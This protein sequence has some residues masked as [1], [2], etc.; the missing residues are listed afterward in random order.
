MKIELISLAALACS[1]NAS[2]A[3]LDKRN[4]AITADAVAFTGNTVD[5]T[6]SLDYTDLGKRATLRGDCSPGQK[7]TIRTAL[8]N[9]YRVAGRAAAVA[10][11]NHAKLK[12]FFK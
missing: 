4:P 6:A 10:D 1:A 2:P 9:C 5:T 8:Y 3:A 12:E 7:E 11:T